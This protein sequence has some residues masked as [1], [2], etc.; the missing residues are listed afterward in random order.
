MAKFEGF[1]RSRLQA[2]RD[3]VGDYDMPTTP[4]WRGVMKRVREARGMTQGQLAEAVGCAQPTISDLETGENKGSTAVPAICE[5]LRIPL[6]IFLAVDEYDE[7]WVEVGRVLRARSM[8]RFL[9]YLA[10]F[11]EES[12]LT[13]VSEDQGDAVESPDGDVGRPGRGH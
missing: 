5:A 3:A 2:I 10:N 12:G 8:R 13:P 7:R 4:Y 11:E 9:N 6:P 1:S